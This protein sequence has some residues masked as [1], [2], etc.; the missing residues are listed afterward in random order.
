MEQGQLP[1][2]I[3]YPLPVAE[4]RLLQTGCQV[5]IKKTLPPG[6]VETGNEH[7]RVVRQQL[8]SSK[9]VELTVALDLGKGGEQDGF[10]Y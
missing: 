9:V 2:L 7:Y 4:E 3:A 8:K 6:Y 5:E 1:L 10:P